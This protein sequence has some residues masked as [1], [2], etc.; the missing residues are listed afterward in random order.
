MFYTCS[1]I[2]HWDV[3]KSQNRSAQITF[4]IQLFVPGSHSIGLCWSMCPYLGFGK[5]AYHI[6]WTLCSLPVTLGSQQMEKVTWP[7]GS[8]RGLR[9]GCSQSLGISTTRVAN[10]T[11]LLS[12]PIPPPPALWG[13]CLIFP[14]RVFITSLSWLHLHN[15]VCIC[16]SLCIC[17]CVC[18]CL[19]MCICFWVSF[20]VCVSIS[21]CVSVCLRLCVCIYVY[22]Y[23]YVYMCRCTLVM[24]SL[25]EGWCHSYRGQDSLVG[26]TPL[27]RDSENL[28]S[29]WFLLCHRPALCKS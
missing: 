8:R 3:Q 20:S 28:C 23:V 9:L 18:L 1:P 21:I 29:I 10:G 2:N 15:T 16:V 11:A 17:V 26:R 14:R 24:G 27:D 25:M 22:V 12:S 19:Y 4:F 5:H 7:V 6:H 13:S